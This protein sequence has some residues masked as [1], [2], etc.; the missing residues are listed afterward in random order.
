MYNI[1]VNV[2]CACI[3]RLTVVYSDYQY[4]VA[5]QCFDYSNSV[6]NEEELP[7]PLSRSCAVD[8][9][10]LVLYSKSA[11]VPAN[12]VDELLRVAHLPASCAN[13]LHLPR[14]DEGQSAA[15]SSG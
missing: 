11:N 7:V 4:L 10:A 2:Y 1:A 8:Q 15:A 6:S 5:R 3:V 12:V 13:S 14:R 9:S